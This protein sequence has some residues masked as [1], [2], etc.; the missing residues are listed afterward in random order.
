MSFKIVNKLA[1]SYHRSTGIDLEDLT[2][3]ANLAYAQALKAKETGI[4]NSARSSFE[5]FVWIKVENHLRSTI[6]NRKYGPIPMIG[7]EESEWDSVWRRLVI[8]D[9]LSKLSEEAVF[10]VRLVVESPNEYLSQSRANAKRRIRGHLRHKGTT[11]RKIEKAF[12]SIRKVL[13]EV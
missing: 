8:R 9:L 6:K 7:R 5:T 10:A 12:E 3:E 2:G 4:Y 11:R 1:R 13:V